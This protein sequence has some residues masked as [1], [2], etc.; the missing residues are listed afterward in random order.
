MLKANLLPLQEHFDG[1]ANG[2]DWFEIEIGF[3]RHLLAG[4][5]L[6]HSP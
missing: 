1:F 2:F 5:T 3:D 4:Q 6:G